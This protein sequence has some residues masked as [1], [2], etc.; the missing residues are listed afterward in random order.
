MRLVWVLSYLLAVKP[1]K[2]TVVPLLETYILSLIFSE[3]P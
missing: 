3:V 2:S 1:F